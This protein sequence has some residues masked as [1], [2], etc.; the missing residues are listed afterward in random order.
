MSDAKKP[1]EE[2][3]DEE[4]EQDHE[5]QYSGTDESDEEDQEAP[6]V[7]IDEAEAKA[8]A[9]DSA[10]TPSFGGG[11]G[12]RQPL[13]GTK[14]KKKKK[15]KAAAAVLSGPP[16]QQLKKHEESESKKSE[17][18]DLW[19]S[20]QAES[21]PK[22]KKKKTA[23]PGV[24]AGKK[25]KEDASKS[26]LAMLGLLGPPKKKA[27]KTLDAASI[28]ALRKKASEEEAPKQK[29]PSITVME[30]QDFAG[31]KVMVEKVMVVGSKDHEEWKKKQQKTGIDAV[32]AA[33]GPK[34]MCT[35][36]NKSDIDWQQ[37][38]AEAKITDELETHKKSG[39]F[40]EKQEFIARTEERWFKKDQA[41]NR[42]RLGVADDV[43][44]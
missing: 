41:E 23:D 4:Y 27:A 36:L 5:Y 20:L 29:V 34:K 9:A 26:S 21:E 15:R 19:A 43:D 25:K 31:E 13:K 33:I 6:L 40:L 12:M 11:R 24:S 18:D 32:L 35:T 1:D 2:E 22:K 8:N 17:V 37:F 7:E 39:G 16:E 44:G 42:K 3:Y 28:A 10:A 30:E 14:V 38:K